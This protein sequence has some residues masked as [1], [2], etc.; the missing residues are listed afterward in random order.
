MTC[1]LTLSHHI[2]TETGL[3]TKF[4][5]VRPNVLDD[6]AVKEDRV[7]DSPIFT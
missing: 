1:Q 7:S 2:A 6:Q 3:A 5:P 4:R